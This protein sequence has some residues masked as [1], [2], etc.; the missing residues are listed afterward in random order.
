MTSGL[1]TRT[2]ETKIFSYDSSKAINEELEFLSNAEDSIDI[3]I[4]CEQPQSI[5]GIE[6]IR[7]SLLDAKARAV[8]TRC[9]TEITNENL[10]FC[11]EL[12][13]LTD[14]LCHLEGVRPNFMISEKEYL[15]APLSLHKEK[16]RHRESQMMTD[17][18]GE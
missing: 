13:N 4:D 7:N 14:E 18:V 15:L 5:V 11:K 10:S 16:M 17:E 9:I 8:K 3:C 6:Q 12:I 2:E 1:T